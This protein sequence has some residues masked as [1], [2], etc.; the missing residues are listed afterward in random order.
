MGIWQAVGI[1][2]LSRILFGGRRGFRG[3]PPG[4]EYWRWRLFRR[5]S[6]MSPEELEKFRQGI[7][8]GC[9]P[10]ERPRGESKP[11]ESFG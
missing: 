7:R 1:L 4:G 6:E 5:W 3:G 9:S 11:F 10:F 2:I 8:S